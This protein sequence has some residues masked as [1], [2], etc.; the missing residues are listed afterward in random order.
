M[1]IEAEQVVG[2]AAGKIWLSI[3]GYGRR[4]AAAD[5]VAFGDDAGVAAGLVAWDPSGHPVF[6][7]DAVADPV[8]GM[9]A[10]RAVLESRARG[11]GELIGLSMVDALRSVARPLPPAQQPVPADGCDTD[12][13]TV[14]VGGATVAVGRPVPPTPD[15]RAS[16]IGAH[17]RSALAELVTRTP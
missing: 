9:E 5:R 11:G 16:P 15:G 7:G 4:G 1:G 3:T 13:W 6:C 8:V 14:D 10:A 17:T 2:S 12:D